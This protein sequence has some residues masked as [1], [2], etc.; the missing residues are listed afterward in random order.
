M[1]R[2][3]AIVSIAKKAR[4]AA[5]WVDS[6]V[7]CAEFAQYQICA[8]MGFVNV[9]AAAFFKRPVRKLLAHRLPRAFAV[10][11]RCFSLKTVRIPAENHLRLTMNPRGIR[12]TLSFQ[13]GL[14]NMFR[15]VCQ[16][17]ERPCRTWV[18]QFVN[19]FPARK[20]Y[21]KDIDFGKR[22]IGKWRKKF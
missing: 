2:G 3:S 21:N 20:V 5:L 7:F 10:I 11:L 6:A 1:R 22:G 14:K 9:A 8:G 16:E 12:H 19:V 15:S 4:G 17:R 18:L 13:T